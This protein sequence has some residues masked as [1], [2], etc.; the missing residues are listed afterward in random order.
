MAVAGEPIAATPR[1]HTK[2]KEKAKKKTFRN[3]FS[4]IRI[5]ELICVA[6]AARKC[7]MGVSCSWC[8]CHCHTCVHVCWIGPCS[9]RLLAP[10]APNNLKTTFSFAFHCVKQITKPQNRN[11]SF[12]SYANGW[13]G[14][15]DGWRWIPRSHPFKHTLF[16]HKFNSKRKSNTLHF[17]GNVY[18]IFKS[19]HPSLVER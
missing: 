16:I 6:S 9:L 19:V 1:S 13:R 3:K 2:G 10:N 5:I 8:W 11:D 12:F 18:L 15:G 4:T 14:F 17:G 7:F